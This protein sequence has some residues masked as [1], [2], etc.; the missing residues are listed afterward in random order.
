LN[1]PFSQFQHKLYELRVTRQ[2]DA[3]W[4]LVNLTDLEPTLKQKLLWDHQ[5]KWSNIISGRH[6]KLRRRDESD[7]PLLRK[8]WADADFMRRFNRSANPLPQNDNDLV[9]ILK[10]ERTALISEKK[11]LHW[12]ILD[13]ANERIGFAGLVDIAFSHRR[14]EFTLG[15]L[16]HINAFAAL[17]ASLLTLHFAFKALHLQRLNSLIYCDN[18]SAKAMTIKLGFSVEGVLR[19]YIIDKQSN[20]P[21]DVTMLS[22]LVDE[23]YQNPKLQRFTRRLIAP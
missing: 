4:A 11:A 5:P 3:A 17:E 15:I 22:L 8:L 20:L 7:L 23:F 12:T 10:A 21:V 16:N 1:I 13:R 6:I 9:N 2:H 18:E 19:H 14:A